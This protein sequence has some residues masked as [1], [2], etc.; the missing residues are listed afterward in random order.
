MLFAEQFCGDEIDITLA[1]A[2]ALY[3]EQRSTP[4]QQMFNRFELSRSE[5][6]L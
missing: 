1:P 5:S 4:F 2:G 3:D 6:G